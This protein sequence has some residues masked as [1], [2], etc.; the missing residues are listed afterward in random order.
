VRHPAGLRVLLA[1]VLGAAALLWQ[2]GRP[3]EV[4]FPHADTGPAA[5]GTVTALAAGRGR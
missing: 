2:L 3:P 5:G 4:Y 1:L